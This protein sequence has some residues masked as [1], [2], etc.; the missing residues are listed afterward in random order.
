VL[1]VDGSSG[2]VIG[3]GTG[4]SWE[5]VAGLLAQATG[6]IEWSV[7]ARQRRRRRRSGAEREAD[8]D[9]ALL[10]AGIGPG[11]PRLHESLERSIRNPEAPTEH[12]E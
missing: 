4:S 3:E 6:D 5:Q 8:I 10:A 2:L 7:G 1:A 9:A 11:D 12:R